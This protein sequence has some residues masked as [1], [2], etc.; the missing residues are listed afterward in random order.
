MIR[1]ALEEEV[2][3]A[4]EEKLVRML[5]ET[6][7]ILSKIPSDEEIVKIDRSSRDER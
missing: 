5:D 2:K 1:R 3:K 6:G 4:E 7:Q